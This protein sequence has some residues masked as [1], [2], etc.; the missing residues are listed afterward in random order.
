MNIIGILAY[1]S[2]ID[3]PGQEIQAVIAKRVEGVETPFKVEFARK[4]RRRDY[5]PTLVPVEEGG[6]YVKSVI[7]VLKE[8]VSEAE[9]ICMLWR[10]ET[11][12]VGSQRTYK[13]SAN[14]GPN[15]VIIDRLENF[16]GIGVVFYTKISANIDNPTPK[17]LAELAI[18]SA[19]AKA[20]AEGRDGISYLIS[21]K[22][23]GIMTP[24]MSEYEKEILRRTGTQS[25]EE[26]LKFLRAD[27]D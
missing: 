20:G 17:K 22:R 13:P 27:S 5:A 19:R 14:P 16:Q 25:L 4:S 11:N 26:A 23:N 21:A 15:T 12:Q 10:R 9:A 1:G 7:L 18:Q 6:A 8:H 24:L 3:D 2:L